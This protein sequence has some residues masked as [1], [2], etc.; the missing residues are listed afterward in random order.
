MSDPQLHVDNIHVRMPGDDRAAGE[1][2]AG[3]IRDSLASVPIVRSREYG[4]LRLNVRVPHGASDAELLR[5]VQRALTH[6]L[7]QE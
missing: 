3:S 2:L 5:A 4:A 6:A 1:R 7:H